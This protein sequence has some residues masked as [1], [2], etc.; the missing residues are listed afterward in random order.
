MVSATKPNI[1]FIEPTKEL[2]IDRVDPGKKNKKE[3]YRFIVKGARLDLADHW[4]DS[5]GQRVRL[6][7]GGHYR[8]TSGARSVLFL[9]SRDAT[10]TSSSIISRLV[11]F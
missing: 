8:A 2:T 5:A 6:V 4:L 3:K 7:A 1:A 11:G 10:E 9:I